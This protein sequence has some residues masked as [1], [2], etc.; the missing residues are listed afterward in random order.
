MKRTVAAICVMII[1]LADTTRII[2]IRLAKGISPFVADKRH[3]HHA[4]IRLDFTHRHAVYILILV[5][6]GMI[7]IA[8]AL[9]QTDQW[10][11]LIVVLVITTAL[12]L[13]LDRLISRSPREAITPAPDDPASLV[14]VPV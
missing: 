11:M 1:P 8:V 4:L 5:H 3:I 7:G 6:I 13:W 9:R 10:F 14:N 2:L 12:C